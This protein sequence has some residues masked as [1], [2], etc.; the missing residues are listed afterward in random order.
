LLLY[1]Q[2][3][4][5]TLYLVEPFCSNVYNPIAI[6]AVVLLFAWQSKLWI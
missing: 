5:W 2:I 6:G 3:V 1:Y 4:Q